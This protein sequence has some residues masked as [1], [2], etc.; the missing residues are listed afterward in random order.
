MKSTVHLMHNWRKD[1]ISNLIT[2]VHDFKSNSLTVCHFLG[3]LGR[4]LNS[5]TNYSFMTFKIKQKKILQNCYFCF[6]KALPA[7]EILLIIDKN[8]GLRVLPLEYLVAISQLS[9]LRIMSFIWRANNDRN[10]LALS[11]Y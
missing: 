4:H 3:Q 8:Y 1:S 7:S 5:A 11:E 9:F 10:S 6:G 2:E